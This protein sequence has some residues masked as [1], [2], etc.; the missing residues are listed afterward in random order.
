MKLKT[1]I[2]TALI[3]IAIVCT[4][5]YV[6]VKSFVKGWLESIFGR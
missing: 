4:T 5:A 1:I 2:F 3:A 6:T